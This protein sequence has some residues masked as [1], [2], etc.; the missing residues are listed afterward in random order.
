MK[1]FTSFKNIILL[2]LFFSI[3]GGAPLLMAAEESEVA[4][5]FWERVTRVEG[6]TDI[7]FQ[8]ITK[9]TLTEEAIEKVGNVDGV[10]EFSMRSNVILFGNK[11]YA[12]QDYGVDSVYPDEFEV[13]WDGEV[14]RELHTSGDS[15]VFEFSRHRQLRTSTLHG[16]PN[17]FVILEVLI[18]SEQRSMSSW[19]VPKAIEWVLTPESLVIE[20]YE[21]NG[22]LLGV[23]GELFEFDCKD[24]EGGGVAYKALFDQ[25]EAGFPAVFVKEF[26]EGNYRLEMFF[27]EGTNPDNF[28]KVGLPSEIRQKFYVDGM[29]FWT[30]ESE[31]MSLKSVKDLPQEKFILDQERATLITDIDKEISIDV[32]NNRVIRNPSP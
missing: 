27:S 5:L 26:K 20:N 6:I 12:K 16:I 3:G 15:H 30:S 1:F 22:E 29:L 17:P 2:V 13:A 19:P 32:K 18:P 28:G 25:R 7:E 14:F 23:K 10:R 21:A 8:I 24:A 11:F 31:F 9:E 4:Q